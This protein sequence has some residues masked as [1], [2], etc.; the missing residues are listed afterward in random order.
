MKRYISRIV[1]TFLVLGLCWNSRA[2]E[3]SAVKAAPAPQTEAKAGK[4]SAEADDV[5]ITAERMEMHLKERYT[6]LT[7]NVLVQ[8]SAVNLTAEKIRVYTDE[9]NKLEKV[10]AEDH[11]AIRKLDGSESATGDKGLYVIK[12]D[13]IVLDGNCTLMQGNNILQCKRIIYDRKKQTISAEGGTLILPSLRRKDVSLVSGQ[14]ADG[15]N[16]DGD[17]PSKKDG[18]DDK[19]KGLGFLPFLDKPQGDK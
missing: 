2:E 4:E 3:T 5:T 14:K 19:V 17:E 6:E 18:K 1:W 7:G 8:D 12:E 9:H 11:V 16:K 15:A 13:T 10:E